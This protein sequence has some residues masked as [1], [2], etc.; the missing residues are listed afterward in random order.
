MLGWFRKKKK[1]VAVET[2]APVQVETPIEES[3]EPDHIEQESA[4][5]SKELAEPVEQVEE[6]AQASVLEEIPDAE[7]ELQAKQIAVVEQEEAEQDEA[8]SRS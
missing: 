7:Q 6:A 1:Q 2:D 8:T 5:Q 4:A 3:V